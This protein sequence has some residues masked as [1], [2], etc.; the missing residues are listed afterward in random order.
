MHNQNTDRDINQNTDKTKSKYKKN[1]M[2]EV[3]IDKVVL[4]IGTGK[5]QANIEKALK[6][7][8]LLTGLNGVKTYAKKR[9][10]AWGI[11]PGMPVGCKKTL[12]NKKALEVLKLMLKAKDNKLSERNFDEYGN[13]NFGIEEYITIPEVKYDPEIG[14]MG[15]Q[16]SVA[17][18]RRGYRVKNRRIK[19]SRIGKNHIVSKQDAIDFFRSMGV[20]VE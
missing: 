12:R 16:V 13:I 20:R 8:K 7:L 11:R 2:R 3:M 4:N 9:I 19:P 6:L 14:I 10:P 17:L 15:L 5:E 1:P 18:A